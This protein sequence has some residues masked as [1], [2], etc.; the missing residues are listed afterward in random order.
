[1]KAKK[2]IYDNVHGYIGITEEELAV[3]DTPL[4]QRLR[5][6]MQLGPAN[7]V[8]PGA[9]HT[10]F[11]HCLGTMFM[12]DQFLRYARSSGEPIT[13]DDDTVQM[14]RLAALLHDIGHYPMSHTVE[15]VIERVMGGRG[16][17]EF[18]AALV[19]SFYGDALSNYKPRE[20]S[21]M[22]CG[23]SKGVLGMLLSSAFDADKVDYLLRDAY[24]TGVAYGNVGVQRLV[25]TA[26]F[27]KGRI[28]FDKDEEVVENFLLGRYHMYR[29]VYHHKTVV[30]FYAMMERIFRGLVDEGFIVHP[31]DLLKHADEQ[32]I[33]AYDDHMV[34][35]A[36]HAYSGTG[37]DAQLRELVR[38]F[39][40]RKPL[41]AAFINPVPG[42]RDPSRANLLVR[43][44]EYDDRKIESFAQK[45]D[46]PAEWIF[47]V[48]LRDLG[49][50]DDKT[51]IFI[52]DCG[53]MRSVQGGRGLVMHMVG[54]ERL[55]DARIY[56]HPRH[57][58]RMAAYMRRYE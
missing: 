2:Q 7:L 34:Y 44:M 30:A 48:Y 9:T 24:H 14:M 37:G 49:L 53:S 23:K 15:H 55:Y 27:E 45:A 21:D 13:D 39:L 3:V 5:N 11:E 28:V 22:I 25:L 17:A 52:R 58:R 19:R 26:S 57:K 38:M 10:R 4:F 36:M 18:G 32:S 35:A 1:M 47:P 6:V 46:V 50:V 56:V 43:G 12:M 42:V 40:G 29:S 54:K 33:A 20:I 51:P 8:Y 41:S 16:H 31:E